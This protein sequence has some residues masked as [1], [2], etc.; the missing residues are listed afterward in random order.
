MTQIKR[1]PIEL[2]RN[3]PLDKQSEYTIKGEVI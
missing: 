1:L 3:M 2:L